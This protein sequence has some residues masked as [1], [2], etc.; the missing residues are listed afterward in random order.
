M[1]MGAVPPFTWRVLLTS[2]QP[3]LVWDILILAALAS[4]AVGLLL[5]RRRGNEGLPWYRVVSFTL[6]LLT[7]V[8]SLNSA[9]ETYSSVLFWVHMVQHLLLIMVV[10]AL[11]VAGSPLSLLVQV[12][13][14][15]RQERIRLMLT[16]APASLL[17]HPLTGVATYTGVIVGT[18]LTSFMQQMMLHPWLHQVEH[19]L[20]LGG[21]YLFLIPLIGDEPIRWHPPYPVRL[22]ALFLA[23]APETVVGIVLL[24]ANHEL[25][26]AYAAVHRTWGPSPLADLNR[27]GGI[28]WAF[29]DGLMMA[30][31]VAVV[32]AYITHGAANATAGGW[33][34]DV[35]R[36]TLVDHLEAT[37]DHSDLEGSD[38][39]EDEAALTAY[40]AMLARL[41]EAASQRDTSAGSDERRRNAGS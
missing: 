35:R 40:N 27:G 25:F 2:W 4:Y 34:E 36:R 8:V 24:Q 20:Y 32:L 19:V 5:A 37:G 1:P 10:P 13:R 33:L 14:G 41:S 15:L 39:D 18:H 29:G 16:S 6:G 38:I 31:I 22:F 28:M 30:L 11:L 9:I 17:T 3:N 12:A 21:G 7:L 23:M 26:P